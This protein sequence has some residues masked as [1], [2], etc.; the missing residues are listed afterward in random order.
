[1][2][3]LVLLHGAI[4]SSS[5]FQSLT[6]ELSGSCAVHTLNFP[7]HGGT[8]EV[9]TSFSIEAFAEHAASFIK[10][11]ATDE[12]V[13]IFGYSMGGYVAIYMARHH[14]IR[15]NKIITLGTKFHWDEATAAKE[16][17]MLQ[18]DTI[19]QKVPAFAQQ[20]QQR[21]QPGNWK[22][23]LNKTAA[24]LGEMGRNNPLRPGDYASIQVPSLIMRGDRDKMVTMEE[25]LAVYNQLPQGQLSI[26]PATP[27]PIEQVNAH[28]LAFLIKHFIGS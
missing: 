13:N 21:H 19:E 25:T 8:P 16:S 11:L 22:G 3:P 15:I 2:T 10:Q 27:H 24:M 5:Q 6:D 23:V 28:M 14:G 20:L 12:P 1:M 17:R 26:L 9:N 18:P 4:G 7:G